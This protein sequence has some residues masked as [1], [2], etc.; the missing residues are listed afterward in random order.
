M[1]DG[2]VDRMVDTW[3]EVGEEVVDDVMMIAESARRKQT[4]DRVVGVRMKK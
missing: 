2:D 4:C 3:K 1:E